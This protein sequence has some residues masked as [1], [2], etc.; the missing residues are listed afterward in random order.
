MFLDFIL[1]SILQKKTILTN[2][3]LSKEQSTPLSPRARK[4]QRKIAF[5]YFILFF[6]SSI[7][8][9]LTS[10]G[11]IDAF[12]LGII[13][14]GAGFLTW[15][16]T[17]TMLPLALAGFCL[18]CLACA[19][20]VWFATGNIILAP[21]I[22]ILSAIVAALYPY[23][24]PIGDAPSSTFYSYL[25]TA[26][27]SISIAIALSYRAFLNPKYCHPDHPI[28]FL[29]NA[30]TA[31]ARVL[32]QQRHISDIQNQDELS[33]E[34]LGLSRLLLDR[35]LQPVN[36]FKGFE[37]IEQFQTSAVRYQNNFISYALSMISHH[38][39]PQ[40]SGYMKEAQNNLLK[41]QQDYK[42]WKYWQWENLW[43]NLS[44][45]PDPFAKDNIMFSGF[46]ASQ[47]GYAENSS[48]TKNNPEKKFLSFKHPNHQQWDYSI[49]SLISNL[50]RQYQ[51]APL[52][53]LPCEPNW[54][55]PLCNMITATSIKA[56]ST[57]YN[58]DHWEQIRDQFYHGLINEFI[59]NKN[60]LIPFRS[61]YTGFASPQIG[62]LVMQAFPLFF[63]NALFPALAQK[64]WEPV[65][66]A[67]NASN[68][69]RKI[70]PIDVGNYAFSRSS[71]YTAIALA[72]KEMGDTYLSE[73]LLNRLDETRPRTS[74][75][76]Y[77][78]PHSCDHLQS[79]LLANHR[80]GV[81]LWAHG[82]EMMA[83][84]IKPQ[85]FH[86]LINTPN[87]AQ[88]D[89]PYLLEAAYEDILVA[90][91]HYRSH[92]NDPTY[93]DRAYLELVLYPTQ[94]DGY[95]SLSIA[96]LEPSSAFEFNATHNP[97]RSFQFESNHQG[98]ARI[99]ANIKGRTGI[100][101]YQKSHAHNQSEAL[102]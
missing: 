46:V 7:I 94:K 92:S 19:M 43:G 76:S 67:L 83:R 37:W 95:N 52:G 77:D 84:S 98:L 25:F 86:D 72:A 5:S 39:T 91:A 31:S 102:I 66:A 75:S 93:N 48:V 26:I 80:N 57:Q 3:Q 36:E 99:N 89:K 10:N 62:G 71:G 2:G 20:I 55:Y 70:W 15:S 40:F 22:W 64:L 35:A 85:G 50:T 18:F 41:K 69:E 21:L 14:P 78:A 53:L 13:F 51:N 61:S 33:P 65:S 24:I 34:A 54:I 79:R 6:V 96:G 74:P 73:K 8:M 100:K 47:I 11:H 88:P 82:V 30:A 45:N 60:K 90:K 97:E 42:I 12:C 28:N 23:F 49:K 38:Q 17:S 58:T 27:L 9:I 56:Y 81:S 44:H 32:D 29:P 59:T 63:L 87:A 101:I 68:W 1:Q 16:G 4:Q